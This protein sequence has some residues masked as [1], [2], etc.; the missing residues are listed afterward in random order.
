MKD[1]A[2]F[3]IGGKWVPPLGGTTADVINPSTEQMVARVA[4][5][6]AAD[7]DAAVAAARAALPSFSA[8]SREERVALLE[9]I[10]ETLEARADDLAQGIQEELGAPAWLAREAQ[11]WMPIEHARVGAAALRDFD[12]DRPLGSTL[13]RLV[14][15]GV[16]GLITPWNWPSATIMCKVVPALAMGCTIVLKPSEYSPLSTQ[17]LIEALDEAGVPPGVLNLVYGEGPVVGRAISEH[18]DIDMVSITGST[19]AGIDVAA[20]AAPTVKRVHQ[21]LG[22]KS[23]NILLPSANIPSAVEAGLKGLMFNSGQ[24]CSAPSRMLVPQARLDEVKEAVLGVI[25]QVQPGPSGSN[26][27]MGPVINQSQFTRIQAMIA[28]GISEGASVVTGG[29]GRPEG[30]ETGYFV[31]PTVFADTSPDM[32]IVKD[33]IF[34]PV[35]VIQAYE[36]VEDAIRL[37]NDT[38]YGLAAYVQGGDIA[39]LREVGARVQAGQVYLNG[40]GLDL[41]DLAAPFG[42]VKQSGNGREWGA[43]AF[44]AFAEI[45]AFIGYEPK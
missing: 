19:R 11:A 9:R 16:C 7:I 17:V 14:P 21:E 25:E 39:E 18:P 22:G 33:E 4:M 38:V 12:F 24:S 42:G 31:K 6:T 27:F 28:S 41:I 35:L 43:Y 8:T 40:S 45:Q 5:G 20:R 23:P 29:L 26:A 34:G 44:E 13:V 3:F 1:L 32:A 30:L 36:D 10:V 37:A 2:N 15:I